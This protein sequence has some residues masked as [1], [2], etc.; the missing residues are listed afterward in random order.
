MSVPPVLDASQPLNLKPV[1]PPPR[2]PK[3]A[4]H[5][6]KSEYVPAA[7]ADLNLLVMFHGLGDNMRSFT[8]LAKKMQLPYTAVLVVEGQIP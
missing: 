8:E 2:R 6:W 5:G 1:S 7:R 3:P 4:L